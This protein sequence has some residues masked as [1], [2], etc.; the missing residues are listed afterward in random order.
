MEEQ[1]PIN[2]VTI[3]TNYGTYKCNIGPVMDKAGIT[4]SQ[5]HR[6][7]G[8]NYDIVKKYY[9]DQVIRMDKDVMAR[10]SYVLTLHGI[11]CSNLLEYIPPTK[12]NN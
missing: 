4:I 11:D 9:T 3:Q 6:L 7:T 12:N 5:M 2:P 1:T 10:I 8:I